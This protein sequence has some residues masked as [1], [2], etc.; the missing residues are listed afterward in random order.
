M[1]R[2]AM[3]TEEKKEARGQTHHCSEEWKEGEAM[4]VTSSGV[5][6]DVCGKYILLE[7][8][9]PFTL[10]DIDR[11]FQC[12]SSG[13]C[14]DL[15]FKASDAK[16]WKLL[17]PESPIR[18]AFESIGQVKRSWKPHLEQDMSVL[19]EMYKG[20]FFIEDDVRYVGFG[21]VKKERRGEGH[22]KALGEKLKE[23]MKAVVIFSP[24]I[25]SRE[26]LATQGYIY[27]AVEHVMAWHRPSRL[28]GKGL[29]VRVEPETGEGQ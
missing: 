10:K 14:K 19:G 28:M 26:L 5:I 6:C 16:D 20:Y 7:E 22:F 2:Q 3:A 1:Q 27:D 13:D 11:E 18:L 8:Y 21:S 12:H 23:G 29:G 17:P 9:Q 24:T 15:L 25:E 4:S